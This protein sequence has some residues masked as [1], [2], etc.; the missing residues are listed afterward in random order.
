M[1]ELKMDLVAMVQMN[2]IKHVIRKAEHKAKKR[3]A[4]GKIFTALV[5]LTNIVIFAYWIIAIA[6]YLA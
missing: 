4:K 6:A 2:H 3:N 1:E 5:Y